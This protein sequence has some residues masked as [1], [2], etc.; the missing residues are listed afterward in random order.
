MTLNSHFTVFVNT[1]TSPKFH[2]EFRYSDLINRTN[3]KL[4]STA[5]RLLSDCHRN[6]QFSFTWASYIFSLRLATS[7]LMTSPMYSMTIV[8]FSKSRPA[9]RPKPWRWKIRRL[10]QQKRHGMWTMKSL[11]LK[12]VTRWFHVRLEVGWVRGSVRGG[13]AVEI[14]IPRAADWVSA[15]FCFSFRILRQ[16]EL[17]SNS[18]GS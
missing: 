18:F 4:N 12:I 8:I 7:F 6:R 17:T 16:S 3:F 13:V 1:H 9:N 5:I 10:P 14:R 15:R 11:S 2:S